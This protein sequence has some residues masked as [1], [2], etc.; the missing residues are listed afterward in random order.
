MT[1]VVCAFTTARCVGRCVGWLH[2]VDN[3]R[4][5]L[6][7]PRCMRSEQYKWCVMQQQHWVSYTVLTCVL[8]LVLS[9]VVFEVPGCFA[10]WRLG[11]FVFYNQQ[12]AG[13]E[14]KVSY[15]ESW[16]HKSSKL[17]YIYHILLPLHPFSIPPDDTHRQHPELCRHYVTHTKQSLSL[18]NTYANLPKSVFCLCA[19]FRYM[20]LYHNANA[21]DVDSISTQSNSP[22][23]SWTGKGTVRQRCRHRI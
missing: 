14:S 10:R 13:Y 11:H 12:N 15:L 1:S 4:T 7:A 5:T 19:S 6:C 21:L 20:H 17:K 2:S 16:T 8:D 3:L 23:G 9:L 18:E 22:K